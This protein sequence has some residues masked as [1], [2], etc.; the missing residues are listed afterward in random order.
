MPKKVLVVEDDPAIA[1]VLERCL[2]NQGYNVSVATDGMDA[3]NKTKKEM[4][5]LISLDILL[6]KMDGIKVCRL[7]RFDHSSKR[8]Q[9]S[10]RNGS[11]KCFRK[12]K[13]C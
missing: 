9:S 5:D 3:L 7:L 12:R 10:C 1:M 2:Q 8:R 11:N 13:E 4:P 6:P